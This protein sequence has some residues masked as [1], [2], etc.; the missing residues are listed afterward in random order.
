[1]RIHMHEKAL[2]NLTGHPQRVAQFKADPEG[3]DQD[4]LTLPREV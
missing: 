4:R 3:Q 2:F 1:M